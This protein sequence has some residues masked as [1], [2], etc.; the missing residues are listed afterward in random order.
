MSDSLQKRIRDLTDHLKTQTAEEL[1]QLKNHRFEYH[2]F[3]AGEV[4]RI[5][6]ASHDDIY[7]L[8]GEWIAV[9]IHPANAV[10]LKQFPVH[11]FQDGKLWSV[12]EL[13]S[14]R[15]GQASFQETTVMFGIVGDAVVE[16][17]LRSFGWN[18]DESTEGDAT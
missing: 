10:L 13:R 4:H 2:I 12:L 6:R 14:H 9:R 3:H 1:E 18:P 8:V 17:E 15:R 5:G 16:K 7:D 11:V